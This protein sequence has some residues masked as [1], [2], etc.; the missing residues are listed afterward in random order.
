[1]KAAQ[2]NLLTIDVVIVKTADYF[3][4]QALKSYLLLLYRSRV[5]RKNIST[6]YLVKKLAIITLQGTPL[7]S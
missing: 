1:M 4:L 3:F 6:S 7:L 5:F 2:L